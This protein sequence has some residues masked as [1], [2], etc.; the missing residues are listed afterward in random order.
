MKHPEYAKNPWAA[1]RL[2]ASNTLEAAPAVGEAWN[3]KH[4]TAQAGGMEGMD[5]CELMSMVIADRLMAV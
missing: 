3:V 5:E 4:R 2:H 1:I